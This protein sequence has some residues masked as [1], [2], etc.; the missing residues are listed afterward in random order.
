MSKKAEEIE[1]E[2]PEKKV[3]HRNTKGEGSIFQRKDG[4][5]CAKIQLGTNEQGKPIIKTFYGAK[6][7]IVRDKLKAYKELIKG[8]SDDQTNEV[9]VDSYVVNWLTT[10]KSIQ[11]KP[12]SY[13]RL[14]AT[15]NQ[16]II[17]YIGYHQLSQL[18][19]EQ[20]QEELI[21]K[22]IDKDYSY[23]S[24]KKA[25]NAINACYKYALSVRKLTYNPV[26][27]VTLPSTHMFEKKTIRWF[28]DDE[29][30]RFKEQCI[31]KYKN[32]IFRYPLG[33]AMIFIMNT[34]LRLG[35]A[36]AIQWCNVDFAEKRLSVDSNVVMAVDRKSETKKRVQI[37][38]DFLKTKSSKRII[39]LNKTAINAL[40]EIKKIRYFGEDSY[41]FCTEEG[42]QNKVRN[43][44]RTYE[45]ILKR[46]DIESCGIHTLRHTFASKLFAKNVDIKKISALLGHSDVS[47]TYNT[48]IHLINEQKAQAVE[49]ID[50]I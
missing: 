45:S 8:A 36:L 17:P 14:E 15:I 2:V 35:E 21:N 12:S 9:T 40:E 46:A 11:L 50:E 5:W 27:A 48:Y 38:Q 33:Y 49:L 26:S 19:P 23:S 1:D 43:F 4:N 41:I 20:I 25:Y 44:C 24:I 32:G 22:M 3:V 30:K 39:P 47:I 42:K 34:G 10:V 18:T 31:F 6:Q 28:N 13:D 37:N 16:N 29:I 7:K